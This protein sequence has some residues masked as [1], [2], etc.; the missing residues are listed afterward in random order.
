MVVLRIKNASLYTGKEN[1]S[2]GRAGVYPYKPTHLCDRRGT[3]AAL[4]DFSSHAS[5]SVSLHK[6]KRNKTVIGLS[7]ISV[8]FMCL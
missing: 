7:I 8:C 6:G 2:L 4:S 5:N 1:L 3:F